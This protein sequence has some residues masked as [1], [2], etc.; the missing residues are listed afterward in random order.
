MQLL[1]LI[2]AFLAVS[3]KTLHSQLES[4]TFEQY[5]AE[6]NL[7]FSESELPQRK[8]IFDSEMKRIQAHNGQSLSWKEGV[9]KFT[10]LTAAE[11]KAFFG[12]VKGSSK[13]F[14]NA[15]NPLPADFKIAP[16]SE[17]PKSVDWREAGI[18]SAVKDQGMCGSCW[19][20]AS[21]AVIESHVAKATGLLFDLSVQ[22][23]RICLCFF[24]LSC[25]SFFTFL[26]GHVRSKPKQM[27]W[28]RWMHGI[29][30]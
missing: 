23:V 3:A 10:V 8:A 21:T 14:L 18:V 19:A 15:A 4:Y 2:S 20:F 7:K 22:Q 5:V 12:R 29:Y 1:V 30:C 6:F 26:D 17:L 13:K 28:Y 24:C 9:N 11:K 16:V 25:Y 27:W